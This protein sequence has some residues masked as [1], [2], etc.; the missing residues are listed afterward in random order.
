MFVRTIWSYSVWKQDQMWKLIDNQ[1]FE[2]AQDK[3]EIICKSILGSKDK[4]VA[5]NKFWEKAK[6]DL[7]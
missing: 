6:P 5:Q 4:F 3:R 1:T 2:R 7:N